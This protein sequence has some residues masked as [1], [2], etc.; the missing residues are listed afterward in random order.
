[1]SLF[2]IEMSSSEAQ[3]VFF[4]YVSSHQGENIDDVKRESQEMSQAI[5]RNEFSLA[6]P[7][8]TSYQFK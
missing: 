6:N 1:M 5:V 7:Q 4:D 2:N 8:M 3:R